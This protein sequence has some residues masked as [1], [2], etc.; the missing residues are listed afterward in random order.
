[1]PSIDAIE[2]IGPRPARQLR[3]AGVKTTD[4]LLKRLAL[5]K[6]RAELA[7]ATGIPEA[8]LQAWGNAADLMRLKGVGSEYAHLLAVSGVETVK[9]LKR[10]NPRSLTGLLTETN[11]KKRLVR[12]LPT[13][14]MVAGWVESAKSIDDRH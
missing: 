9:E 1:M 2:G 12:R 4:G 3:K 13:D 11:D 10:R 14:A 7:K 6:G 8:D 5:K